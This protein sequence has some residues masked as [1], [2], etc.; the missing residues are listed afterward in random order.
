MQQ[1][2][3]RLNQR[4]RDLKSLQNLLQ[5]GYNQLEKGKTSGDWTAVDRIEAQ[6]KQGDF[7]GN[8]TVNLFLIE[9][10]RAKRIRQQLQQKM[11][12][13]KQALDSEAFEQVLQLVA[14]LQELGSE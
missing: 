8:H 10:N 11:T 13:L 1:Y 9:L 5:Q 12:E 6:I 3:V 4:L 2:R 14:D 7:S